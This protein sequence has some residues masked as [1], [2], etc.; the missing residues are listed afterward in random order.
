[1]RSLSLYISALNDEEY[2]LFTSS[3]T[4]IVAPLPP[5]KTDD[6]YTNLT[7]PM[8][9]AR[10]FLCGRCPDFSFSDLD[11]VRI[12]LAPSNAFLTIPS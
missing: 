12:N 3:V 7:F 2:T 10:L 11:Q 4:I 1:M 9:S 6:D 5:P 8:R